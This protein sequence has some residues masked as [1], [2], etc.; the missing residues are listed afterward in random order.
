M[1]LFD[2][3]AAVS[4]ADCDVYV[5]GLL[6]MSATWSDG[7]R[8]APWGMPTRIGFQ[9]VNVPSIATLNL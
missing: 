4:S 9:S 5:P 1:F 7:T 3:N 6:G 2:V 8:T